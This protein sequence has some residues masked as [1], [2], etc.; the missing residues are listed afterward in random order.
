M[1]ATAAAGLLRPDRPQLGELGVEGAA[2]FG[3][4]CSRRLVVVGSSANGD[5]QLQPAASDR[6]YRS[7]LFG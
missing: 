4:R 2:P 5:A 6:V 1:D 3:E 7:E